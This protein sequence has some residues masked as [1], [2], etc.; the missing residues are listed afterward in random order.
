MFYI[1]L[2]M[3]IGYYKMCYVS[4]EKL[5]C[6]NCLFQDKKK[7]CGPKALKMIFND[8]HLGMSLEQIELETNFQKEVG[9]SLFDLYD[10]SEKNGLKPKALRLN[11]EGIYNINFPAI[12]YIKK[13][14]FIVLDSVNTGGYAFV[15]DPARGR[16][17]I[18]L[19]HLCKM[20]HGEILIFNN[21]FAK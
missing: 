19:S 20:W 3:L 17:K 2:F 18:S 13:S 4:K 14:H 11:L 16:F 12:L 7:N 9:T 1:I 21:D 15:R 6:T 10:V 8:F 5:P